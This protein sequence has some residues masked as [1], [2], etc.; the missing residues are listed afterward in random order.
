MGVLERASEVTLLPLWVLLGL[1][2]FPFILLI[3]SCLG[4]VWRKRLAYGWVALAGMLLITAE[5]SLYWGFQL[6]W[7]GGEF[8]R[9]QVSTILSYWIPIASYLG[10][11]GILFLLFAMVA[12]ILG[13]RP[14]SLVIKTTGSSEDSTHED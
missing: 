7:A 2:S 8:T 10:A 6:A 14:E 4:V 12:L 5:I 3:I 9:R 11:A 13:D 1:V